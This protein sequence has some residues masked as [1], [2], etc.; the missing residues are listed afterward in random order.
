MDTFFAHADDLDKMLDDFERR[1]ENSGIETMSKDQFYS[2]PSKNGANQSRLEPFNK[3]HNMDAAPDLIDLSDADFGPSPHTASIPVAATTDQYSNQRM[4]SIDGIDLSSHQMVEQQTHDGAHCNQIHSDSNQV[5]S[6]GDLSSYLQMNLREN[7]SPEGLQRMKLTSQRVDRPEDSSRQLKNQIS[8]QN[9]TSDFESS[10]RRDVDDV[11]RQSELTGSST[12]LSQF[13]PLLTKSRTNDK[14]SSHSTVKVLDPNPISP[15]ISQ[16]SVFNHMP[17]T[18]SQSGQL[19]SNT[20]NEQYSIPQSTVQVA[21]S[22]SAK[23][24]VESS[25]LVSPAGHGF[26]ANSTSSMQTEVLSK[27]GPGT[28]TSESAGP[29]EVAQGALP[30]TQVSKQTEPPSSVTIPDKSPLITEASSHEHQQSGQSEDGTHPIQSQPVEAGQLTPQHFTTGP[31][32]SSQPMAVGHVTQHH[33]MEIR[34]VTQPNPVA[35]G[36][37]TLQYPTSTQ[38]TV[39]GQVTPLQLMASGCASVSQLNNIGHDSPS[40]ITESTIVS[41]VGRVSTTVA[42]P[43]DDVI[44]SHNPIS[45]HEESKFQ[46]PTSQQSDVTPVGFGDLDNIEMSRDEFE[47]FF[48]SSDVNT[49]TQSDKQEAIDDKSCVLKEHVRDDSLVIATERSSNSP[50]GSENRKQQKGK[51][52]SQDNQREIVA[53]YT[54]NKNVVPTQQDSGLCV[55]SKCLAEINPHSDQQDVAQGDQLSPGITTETSVSSDFDGLNDSTISAIQ[56]LSLAAAATTQSLH[57]TTTMAN[58][59]RNLSTAPGQHPQEITK[60]SDIENL[61]LKQMQQVQS[62]CEQ[63]DSHEQSQCVADKQSALRRT[64]HLDFSHPSQ[65]RVLAES[66][67]PSQTIDIENDMSTARY[68]D[69]ITEESLDENEE[70]QNTETAQI[71]T[72]EIASTDSNVQENS[73]KDAPS[74]FNIQLPE[75]AYQLG[76]VAPVWVPDPEAPNCMKCATKFTFTKRRHHCRACGKVFC[77]TCCN[78]KFK[79][80]YMDNKEAR[81]CVSCNSIL[82]RVEA[83]RAMNSPG[84]P[85]RSPNPNNPAEYCSTVSPLEQA[86]HNGD[87]PPPSV[88]VPVAKSSLRRPNTE[89]SQRQRENRHVRF[90]DGIHPGG[91][92]TDDSP[93]AVE[94]RQPRAQRR[95]RSRNAD[96]ENDGNANRTQDLISLIPKDENSLPPVVIST[97]IKGEYTLEE[98]PNNEVLMEKLQ[99][100]SIEPVVF[101]VKRNLFVLVKIINLDCCVNRTCWCFTTKGMPIVGQDEIV[102]VMEYST[103]EKTVPR[104]IFCHFNN[105]YEEASKGNTVSDMGHSI[106]AHNFLGSREHGGILYIRPTFQCLRKLLLPEAPYLFG[107]LLQKWETP[108][109][110]VFPIRLMLR[111]GAEYRYAIADQV[112]ENTSCFGS[113]PLFTDLADGEVILSGRKRVKALGSKV[114]R[115]YPCPLMSV[116]YRKP[117][118]GEIG[119]TIMHLL[120]DFKNYQY[121]LPQIKGVYIHMEDRQTSINFPKNRYDDIMKVLNN[122]NEHVMAMGSNFSSSA[123]SHLVCIQNDDGHYQTQAINIQ[124]KPRK[125]T[126]A[127]F[128]VFNGALKS[129]SGLMAKSSI[130]EDGLMVQIPADTM[131]ALR[132][133]LREMK[134][135]TIHCGAIGTENPEESV[136]VQWVEDDVKINIGVVSPVDG[137]SMEGISSLRIQKSTDYMGENR[138]IRWTEVFFLNSEESV[139]QRCDTVDLSRLAET[140]SKGC[141]MALVPHLDGLKEIH[142][143]KIGLRVTIGAERVGYEIGSNGSILPDKF[144][145]E[146][147]NH[148]IPVITSAVSQQADGPITLELIFYILE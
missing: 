146:L 51:D 43:P 125:V 48:E 13:T 118:Y 12:A 5:L 103:E 80:K 66:P 27:F 71:H 115:D 104:D 73:W 39:M 46:L 87:Q 24:A 34:Q 35:V 86:R 18:E 76:H 106:F 54:D 84:G 130:V 102:M 107:V 94:I 99:S 44:K 65:R 90:S 25:Q 145:S 124:N 111:L 135:F 69:E 81:V 97:G 143:S 4:T 11:K 139:D 63:S 38:S 131:K 7:V 119:H 19:V 30:N 82:Q 1:E 96:P 23:S 60:P 121:M 123:D 68:D 6:D 138:A 83:I 120:A 67:P 93:S 136:I 62:D 28:C 92:L 53:S 57:E 116:R 74:R 101:V 148:L 42:S 9:T 17:V 127:S 133:A 41:D 140:L 32:T 122:S 58:I 114:V 95:I 16:D 47:A 129:S 126:G 134:D 147:D 100:D 61:R 33:P 77:S 2:T 109:A 10:G 36:L 137:K 88:M 56:G 15:I 59:D 98:N 14:R 3:L 110:M 142:M 79:L 22:A 132:H 128:V 8:S 72:S 91:D 141:C 29:C 20:G 85:I 117:V 50:F 113:I 49:S 105:V 26:S 55:D 64:L 108:W 144:M 70:M 31:S 40:N 112:Y 21:F 89:G 45:L 78:T 37:T 52:S 75:S